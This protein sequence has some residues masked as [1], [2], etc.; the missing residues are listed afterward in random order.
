MGQLHYRLFQRKQCF[1]LPYA[2][3][4]LNIKFEAEPL[5]ITYNDF[6]AYLYLRLII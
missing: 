6:Y 1:V 5:K 3:P 2:N 4:I